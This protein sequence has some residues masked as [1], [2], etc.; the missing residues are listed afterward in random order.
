MASSQSEGPLLLTGVAL[1]DHE[2]SRKPNSN[3]LN[4]DIF[5]SNDGI[6][7]A[8]QRDGNTDS[9]A[10]I[11]NGEGG[12]ITTKGNGGKSCGKAASSGGNAT[13][14]GKK[15][16][17]VK[18]CCGDLRQYLY[19]LETYRQASMLRKGREV[20]KVYVDV[21]KGSS[22]LE[23]RFS[24][25]EFGR[26]VLQDGCVRAGRARNVRHIVV[27]RETLYCSGTGGC[28]RACGG[29]GMCLVGCDKVKVRGHKCSFRVKLTMR[30]G[31]VDHWFVEIMGSHNCYIMTEREARGKGGGLSLEASPPPSDVDKMLADY[32]FKS[33]D[34]EDSNLAE[35]QSQD[36]PSVDGSPL[37]MDPLSNPAMAAMSQDGMINLLQPLSLDSKKY[38]PAAHTLPSSASLPVTTTPLLGL[39][40]SPLT[41][42]S[43]SMHI[44][45]AHCPLN[46][47]L[48]SESYLMAMARNAAAAVAMSECGVVPPS[49]TSASPLLS[50]PSP[51]K[52]NS[53]VSSSSSP[54]SL[55]SVPNGVGL[56]GG[57][58][59]P[60]SFFPPPSMII[61][62]FTFIPPLPLAEDVKQN[63]F[64]HMD[65][66]VMD[67]STPKATKPE[68]AV[69][70]GLPQDLSYKKA[71][72]INGHRNP[73]KNLSPAS[74]CAAHAYTEDNHRS[75]TPKQALPSSPSSTASLTAL[76]DIPPKQARAKNNEFAV[77]SIPLQS[78]G[79]SRGSNPAKRPRKNP[80]SCS[81]SP[82]SLSK[83]NGRG[84]ASPGKSPIHSPLFVSKSC[85]SSP[86]PLSLPES[87]PPQAP[88][89]TAQ[90]EDRNSPH[91][92]NVI[93]SVQ[94]SNNT[95]SSS[96][97]TASLSLLDNPPTSSA[98]SNHPCELEETPE[99]ESIFSSLLTLKGLVG[100][101]NKQLDKDLAN[102]VRQLEAH[103]TQ[104]RNLVIKADGSKI[105][106]QGR[107]KPQ[108]EFDF[109]KYNTRH[110]AL[111]IAYL[112]WN[113]QGFVVQED[114][115]N[116]VEAVLFDALLRTKLIMSRET[117]N[118]HRCGRTDK[119]VSALGQVISIDLRTNLLSGIGVKERPG[120]TAHERP[121]D[122]TTE[123]RY[124]HIL[125][126]VLP[127]EIRVLAWAP[128]NINFSARF[129]CKK[130]T[131]KYYFPKGNLNI[132]VMRNAAQKLIGE[133]DFRNLC[134]M[135]I[136]NGVVNFTRKIF[137]ADITALDNVTDGYSMCE[138]TVVGQAF[139]WHQIRCIVAVLFLIGQGKEDEEVIDGL[140][141][142]EENPRKPQYSMASEL[143]LVLF[144]CEYDDDLDWVYEADWHE[145]NIRHFQQIWAQH[146]VKSTMLKRM[147][148]HLDVAKVE[149]E[150][151]IA[152]WNELSGPVLQQS[153][154]I[155]PGN[156]PRIYK[157]L[158]KR[159]MCES[160]E[161]RMEYY[162]KRNKLTVESDGTGETTPAISAVPSQS[163]VPLTA[164]SSSTPQ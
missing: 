126:K 77:S 124:A 62:Q 112:G 125:N 76:E 22:F 67:L 131:Y 115:D 6:G 164:S 111:K 94:T 2:H 129:D 24:L 35:R 25:T 117:S 49:P 52:R 66:S 47:P 9:A 100:K 137:K 50:V 130:R 32:E 58:A 108:R 68:E 134:K 82:A 133:H 142:V 96:E 55:P 120:G 162:A 119:G 135:D 144:D 84:A 153:D 155:I 122:N 1:S 4:G 27:A 93:N 139:L 105:E 154:W 140:L 118:Y 148:G 160:L 106:G 161:D 95:R 72:L 45:P 42:S 116:T 98:S 65:D 121:G 109:N 104:L 128:V 88:V 138:L 163:C 127:P 36:S 81:F 46:M 123:I 13:Y 21:R 99:D 87:S 89:S 8:L 90:L 53:R 18:V 15:F 41:S 14:G 23:D 56:G 12:E 17:G 37:M 159:Q 136:G 51:P 158:F 44:S 3:G 114:T 73:K 102:R 78:N 147:L 71:P 70:A 39:S 43:P 143:P 151:D 157:P 61:P 146:T 33:S 141:N 38:L 10:P 75:T 91:I 145:D 152:P 11:K 79:R 86:S 107:K 54:S 149:T 101:S 48:L 64:S 132:E 150:S 156:K 85:T 7:D 59:F 30:L 40:G 5:Q 97:A 20:H 92:S 19:N 69:D 26:V 83:D 110:V 31:F 63:Q 113:Y 80:P 60:S 57:G 74:N 16:K 29:Y 103:V 28:R 34:G